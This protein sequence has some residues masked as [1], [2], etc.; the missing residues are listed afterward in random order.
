MNLPPCPDHSQTRHG[1]ATLRSSS[2]EFEYWI[3]PR[4]SVIFQRLFRWEYWLLLVILVLVCEARQREDRFGSDRKIF[5]RSSRRAV[6]EQVVSVDQQKPEDKTA[7]S[8]LKWS[9]HFSSPQGDRKRVAGTWSAPGRG[10][11]VEHAFFSVYSQTKRKMGSALH[12]FCFILL[13]E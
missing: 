3:R 1:W 6:S 5:G 13:D 7:L 8:C 2:N 9:G 12:L 11:K 10:W 4:V